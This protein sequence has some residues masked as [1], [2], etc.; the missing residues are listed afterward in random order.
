MET[1]RRAS[2]SAWNGFMDCKYIYSLPFLHNT[3]SATNPENS[4]FPNC[5]LLPG[6]LPGELP[7]KTVRVNCPRLTGPWFLSPSL[8]YEWY[9]ACIYLFFFGLF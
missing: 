7:S 2:A 3:R 1:A 6:G 4:L 9:V 5:T 8:K